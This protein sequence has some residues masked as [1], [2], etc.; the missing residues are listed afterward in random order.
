MFRV[1]CF[2]PISTG[3]LSYCSPLISQHQTAARTRIQFFQTN[4]SVELIIQRLKND[5]SAKF[6]EFLACSPV[7]RAVSYL[8][9]VARRALLRIKSAFT[10]KNAEDLISE[11]I[12]TNE[13]KI[14]KK[15]EEIKKKKKKKK[16][17]KSK[18]NT[19]HKQSEEAN[20]LVVK[21]LM[22]NV[23]KNLY[24]NFKAEEIQEIAV[25]EEV[26]EENKPQEIVSEG[27][28]TVE[29]N[30]R[31]KR[32]PQPQ[33]KN[34]KYPH[35]APNFHPRMQNSL[36]QTPKNENKRGKP[37]ETFHWQSSKATPLDATISNDN[38]FPPL[39][40][41]LTPII[42]TSRLHQEIIK[43]NSEMVAK[44]SFK[45]PV[46]SLIINK[47]NTCAVSLFPNASVDLFGSYGSG[48][49]LADS[50]VDLAITGTCFYDRKSLQ[51]ACINLGELLELL[52]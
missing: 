18:I 20:E 38:D 48:L 35:K 47:L 11:V 37:K 14:E 2:N 34:K 40:P 4:K 42:Q 10:E 16:P 8:D 27:F 32:R 21:N 29:I 43:F 9:I 36:T 23:M 24:E 7:D 3:I 44:V 31:N 49:A 52:P 41:S 6:L 51:R 15:K 17:N 1:S 33:Q 50:D 5:H 25:R 28:Q 45:Y 12:K 19:S 22:E 46:I 26:I 39:I 13:I 30:K